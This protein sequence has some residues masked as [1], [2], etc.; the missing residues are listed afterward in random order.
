M[1]TAHDLNWG[2]LGRD[3]ND[4][5]PSHFGCRLNGH[6]IPPTAYCIF[7]AGLLQN[8]L[9]LKAHAFEFVPRPCLCDHSYSPHRPPAADEMTR[10]SKPLHHFFLWGRL[11]WRGVPTDVFKPATIDICCSPRFDISTRRSSSGPKSVDNLGGMRH[12]TPRYARYSLPT[13]AR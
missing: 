7:P 6:S 3:D 1:E 2:R 13:S 11:V 8:P 5:T 12:L 9:R 10:G 4:D